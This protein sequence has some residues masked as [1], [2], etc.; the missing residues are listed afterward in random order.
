MPDAA[1]YG[2]TRIRGLAWRTRR[3][4]PDR[5]ANFVGGWQGN[6][7][8]SGKPISRVGRKAESLFM[9]GCN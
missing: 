6:L 2:S 3:F 1:P 5:V 7:A 9:I 4:S 8:V